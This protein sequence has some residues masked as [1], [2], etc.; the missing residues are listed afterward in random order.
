MEEVMKTTGGRV[1]ED[2]LTLL[3]CSRGF[4]ETRAADE[5]KPKGR[6]VINQIL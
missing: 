3:L 1:K 5:G 2:S 4:Q 6:C